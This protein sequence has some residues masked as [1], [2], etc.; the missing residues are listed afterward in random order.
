[1]CVTQRNHNL[2]EL[3]NHLHHKKYILFVSYLKKKINKYLNFFKI[4][5][6]VLPSKR[7]NTSLLRT[8]F[9]VQQLGQYHGISIAG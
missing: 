6:V 8:Y 9:N 4:K 3:F 1:M 7:K 2:Y 5:Y